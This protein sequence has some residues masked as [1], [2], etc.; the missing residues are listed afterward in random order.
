MGPTDAD[1][2]APPADVRTGFHNRS[3]QRKPVGADHPGGV[4]NLPREVRFPKLRNERV[5]IGENRR[6]WNFTNARGKIG[7]NDERGCVSEFLP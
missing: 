1:A 3:E 7:R 6:T 4:F 2:V 5:G